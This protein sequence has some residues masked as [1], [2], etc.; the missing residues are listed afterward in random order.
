MRK[1]VLDI[2]EPKTQVCLF[3]AAKSEAGFRPPLPVFCLLYSGFLLPYLATT[4][5]FT[6]RKPGA[7]RR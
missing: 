5:F 4:A 6:D 2:G 7:S 3:F 1:D